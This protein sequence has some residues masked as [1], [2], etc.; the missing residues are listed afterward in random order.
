MNFRNPVCSERLAMVKISNR[1]TR[2][3]SRHYRPYPDSSLSLPVCNLAANTGRHYYFHQHYQ[4]STTQTHS[5]QRLE[6][7]T[8]ICFPWSPGIELLSIKRVLAIVRPPQRICSDLWLGS[9]QLYQISYF[10]SSLNYC[11]LDAFVLS[12][13]RQ[14]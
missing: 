11:L 1:K 13:R 14:H 3:I 6:K 8:L 2:C 9:G 12:I 5:R 10:R 7:K 4:E